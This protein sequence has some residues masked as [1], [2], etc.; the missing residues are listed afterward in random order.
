MVNIYE[1]AHTSA[2]CL[3]TDIFLADVITQL[4]LSL[5]LCY[6]RVIP[7]SWNDV[8]L[9]KR[10]NVQLQAHDRYS[11]YSNQGELPPFP[12]SFPMRAQTRS[13]IS[14]DSHQGSV[15]DPG[16]IFDPWPQSP[17]L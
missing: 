13:L 7:V 5:P 14:P 17:H 15:C 3:F 12:S 6:R 2:M 4:F 1:S 9:N 16:L 8:K 11:R 10:T